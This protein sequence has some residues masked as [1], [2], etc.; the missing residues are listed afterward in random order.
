MLQGAAGNVGELEDAQGCYAAA[1]AHCRPT[2]IDGFRPPLVRT[3][4]LA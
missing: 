3:Q 2:N 4:A 1:S